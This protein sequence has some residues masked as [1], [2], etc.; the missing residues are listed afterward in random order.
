MATLFGGFDPS[1]FEDEA[2]AR[3]GKT[4]AFQEQARR[5]ADYSQ[6]DWKRYHAEHEALCRRFAATSSWRSG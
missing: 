4:E 2:K 1:Q 3:W 6:E 5:T